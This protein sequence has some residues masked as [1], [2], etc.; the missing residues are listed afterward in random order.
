MGETS[1]NKVNEYFLGENGKI[2]VGGKVLF[3]DSRY[4]EDE[5][6]TV[7][8]ITYTVD[9]ETF[10]S[11]VSCAYFIGL[12][13]FPGIEFPLDELYP[14][15]INYN[16]YKWKKYY[17]LAESPEEAL[18]I[19][20]SMIDEL[21]FNLVHDKKP[22]MYKLIENLNEPKEMGTLPVYA[23]MKCEYPFPCIVRSLEWNEDPVFVYFENT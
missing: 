19:W 4:G 18:K 13:E 22:K 12:E 16:V 5:E 20:T 23:N 8:E 10:H 21:L 2:R 11:N 14:A 3:R 6:F 17:I 1:K 15:P 7:T 9:I